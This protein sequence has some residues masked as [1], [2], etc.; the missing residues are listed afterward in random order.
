[1][2][3]RLDR[4]NAS[5]PMVDER[6]YPASWF[7]RLWQSTV[8]SIEGFATDIEGLVS[9]LA[10]TLA[11]TVA[12][13]TAADAAQDD[14]ITALADAAAAA[15]AAAAAQATATAALTQAAADIRYVRQDIGAAWT[16]ATGTVSRATFATY[17][18]QTVS[19]G[20][21][22][23]EVQAIDDHVKV[24]SQRLAAL[25]DDLKANGALT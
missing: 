14:A 11:A 2:S 15:A 8:E 24:L 21:V 22:Q 4:L 12:A 6:R 17:A 18:G 3:L 25:I 19:V 1:M 23:A 10:D 13:Q 9:D 20:Y 16:V 5:N 7:G